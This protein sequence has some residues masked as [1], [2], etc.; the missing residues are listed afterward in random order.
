MAGKGS[1]LTRAFLCVSAMKLM[2]VCSFL[3]SMPVTATPMLR[4]PGGAWVC[5][6]YFCVKSDVKHV[7][8]GWRSCAC[9]PAVCTLMH[10]QVR[11]LL[12]PTRKCTSP[13]PTAS[14]TSSPTPHPTPQGGGRAHS[15]VELREVAVRPLQ[16]RHRLA[17]LH[18]P[19][20]VVGGAR[21]RQR[22]HRVLLAHGQVA[23]GA[24]ACEGAFA[25][26]RS[27]SLCVGWVARLK[28]GGLTRG[29]GGRNVR[30]QAAQ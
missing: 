3:L 12:L 22:A 18:Q 6:I 2:W 5:V 11:R 15:L 9:C 1:G 23:A 30:L 13:H 19:G 24:A 21:A 16:L 7:G 10:V 28:E 27:V 26:K 29:E 17:E 14:G 8:G 4:V 20:G 25:R